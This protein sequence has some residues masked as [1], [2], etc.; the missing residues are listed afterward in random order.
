[1]P[2]INEG[3]LLWTPDT[4]FR[5]RARMT[6]YM[7]WLARERGV[8]VEDYDALWRWSVTDV[9]DFW[10]SI[11]DY[12]GMRSPTPYECVLAERRMPGA[13]WFPGA[14]LNYARELLARGAPD[15]VCLHHYSE[16]RESGRITRAELA[17]QVRIVATALRRMGVEPGDRV[18][19]F[20]PNIPEAVI[21]F[22]AAASIGAIW[23]GCSPDFGTRS[24]LD[25]YTQIEPKVLFSVDGYRYGGQDFDRLAELREI[26]AAL[27]SLAQVVHLPYLHDGDD[28]LPHAGALAWQ[29]VIGGPDPGAEAFEFAL[30]PFDHPLWILFSSGT[31]GLPKA[32]VHGHGGIVLE[33][34]KYMCLH[35]NL[36]PD[37]CM[38]F[39]TTTGWMMWN[40]LL[41]STISGAAAVL[42][43]GNP[44]APAPDT[45]WRIAAESGATF[46][47]ASPTYVGLMIRQGIV[48]R[49]HYDL[50]RL[51]AIMLTGS[52]A[53]P[54]AMAWF[55]DHVGEDLW[56]TTQSGGT[57]VC[58]AFVGASPLLPVHAAEI[59]TRMLGVDAHA[60]NDAGEPV[61][62]EVGE[63]VICKP[64]PSMPLRFWNDPGD[65][66][67][68]ESY[69]EMFPGRWRHGDFI[70]INARGGSYIYGRSDSTLNRHG[71]R[72][73]TAEVYRAVEQ[74]EQVLDSLV[75]N[76]DLPGGR[77]FM[78]LFVALAPGVQLD[79]GL[80]ARIRNRLREDYSPRHVPDAIYQVEAIPYTLTGKKMEVPVRRVL[81][82]TAPEQAFS[83]DAMA[84]PAAGEWFVRFRAEHSGDVLA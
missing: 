76:L 66:R 72:I 71:V 46:F 48:P 37:S 69:F 33:E 61:I 22:L 1:M 81:M 49:E 32:I 83:R 73:G 50:G 77:F 30:L 36:G 42:Y 6:D 31:T 19:G 74:I 26:V 67:Y 64:M 75:V 27:P 29:D 39:Y 15:S 3:D 59:Q 14:R 51:Q 44:L 40:A 47:G 24:V 34:L 52:P 7:R 21:A 60:F 16:L 17:R 84:N 79:A 18:V 82:G 80:E 25:R 70:R 78:P 2:A 28:R 45:L 9:E 11:W 4:A 56:V 57:D 54:E 10:E 55:Y 58:S 53:T 65:R 41:S 35:S 63:L 13:R 8:R 23:A 12:F 38:F 68:F 62:G 20:L 5:E 43:D